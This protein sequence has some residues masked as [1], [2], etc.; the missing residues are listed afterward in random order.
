MTLQ[1][2]LGERTAELK[3]RGELAQ[4]Y[5][6]RAA[7]MTRDELLMFVG[8]MCE[9]LTFQGGQLAQAAKNIEALSEQLKPPK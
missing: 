6:V 8:E 4:W 2:R 7:N 3:Q 5:G 9:T 1:E